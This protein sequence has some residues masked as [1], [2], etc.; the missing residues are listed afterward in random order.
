MNIQENLKDKMANKEKYKGEKKIKEYKRKC[1]ACGKVWHS[2]VSREEELEK[3]LKSNARDKQVAGCGMCSGNWSALGAA[4]Q[5]ERNE[6]SLGNELERLR[7]CP[8]CHSQNYD[9]E[10]ISYKKE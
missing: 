6:Q 4:T 1:K 2:L 3:K 10:I 7:G 9:E 5:A 8:N